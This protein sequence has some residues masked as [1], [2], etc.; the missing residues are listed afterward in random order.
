MWVC[1]ASMPK[2]PK[3]EIP[4]IFPP[5]KEEINWSKMLHVKFFVLDAFSLSLLQSW[6]VCASLMSLYT[7]PAKLIGMGSGEKKIHQTAG[8]TKQKRRFRLYTGF[9]LGF[10]SLADCSRYAAFYNSDLCWANVQIAFSVS[11]SWLWSAPTWAVAAQTHDLQRHHFP[12]VTVDKSDLTLT[13]E[14]W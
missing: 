11:D 13:P 8:G 5:Q 4:T 3:H 2:R 9:D 14:P 6:F 10:L 7:K 1:V 12:S